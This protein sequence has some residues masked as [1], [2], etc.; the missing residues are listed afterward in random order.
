MFQAGFKWIKIIYSRALNSIAFLP[1]IIALFFLI[2]SFLMLQLDFSGTGKNIKIS[3]DWLSLKDANTARSIISSVVSGIIS[4]TVFSFTMVMIL[5]N[6]AASQMSNRVLDQLIGNRFQQ[7]VLGFYIGTIVYALFLLSAIRD[8]DSGI[9]VPAISTYLLIALTVT[10]IFIFIYFLHYITQTIKYDT[11]IHRIYDDTLS[12]MKK[13]CNCENQQEEVPTTEEGIYVKAFKSGIYQGFDPEPLLNICKE[14]NITI[15]FLFPVTTYL[16]ENTPFCIISGKKELDEEF[17][18]KLQAVI[19][20]HLGQEINI[21]YHYGFHKLMEI[22]MKALSPGI[23]DPGTAVISLRSM[24]D[25]LLY[26]L[27]ARPETIVK[28]ETGEIRIISKE[29][30][31]DRMIREFIYPIWHYGKND[32]LL[33]RE[34]HQL[35]NQLKSCSDKLEVNKLSSLVSATVNGY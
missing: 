35:L 13:N 24:V 2:V 9:Y 7:F 33:Q 18:K 8:V 31:F 15:T 19:N 5:L 11:I 16:L 32:P 30:D 3:L 6:Q 28:D 27:N 4:L 10:D 23:N 12:E 25:L 29:K 14:E 34:M 17:M 20:I 21:S 26:R 1:A 22:A